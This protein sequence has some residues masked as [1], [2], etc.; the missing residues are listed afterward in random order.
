MNNTEN[1]P[2]HQTKIFSQTKRPRT[3][4]EDLRQILHHL[5]K[6][7]TRL[8]DCTPEQALKIPVNF[9]LALNLIES[10]DQS[11]VNIES[12]TA[13]FKTISTGFRTRMKAFI[14]KVGG[15]QALKHAREIH[16][17]QS[18][19][20]WWFVDQIW[21]TERRMKFI[22]RLRNLGIL[23]VI[24]VTAGIIY[25]QYFSPDPAIKASFRHQQNAENY[26]ML[27]DYENALIETNTAL[28]YTPESTDLL[29]LKGVILDKLGQYEESEESYAKANEFLDQEYLFYV[30]R[31]LYYLILEEPELV[32]DDCE[33]ALELN[34][35]SA[36]CYMRQGQAYELMG[37]INSAL[38]RLELAD[39]AAERLGNAQLQAIIRV[40]L[41]NIIQKVSATPTP[42]PEVEN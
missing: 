33:I 6:T 26:F 35:D 24:M 18:D 37:N 2:R 20:W 38:E 15:R 19:H 13:Q 40:N 4:L 11:G 3:Q 9:D 22:R 36:L 17:P 34:P 42:T 31:S 23:A 8:S 16:Q 30:Q 14:L 29:I 39:A 32:I 12:Q 21:A 10:L 27:G 25:N 5:E 1:K 7:V 41:S 28:S